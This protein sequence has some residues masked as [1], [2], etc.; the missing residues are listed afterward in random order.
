MKSLIFLTFLSP[1]FFFCFCNCQQKTSFSCLFQTSM[2]RKGQ[3]SIGEFKPPKKRGFGDFFQR[4][5][6]WKISSKFFFHEKPIFVQERKVNRIGLEFSSEWKLSKISEAFSGKLSSFHELLHSSKTQFF[7]RNFTILD[8]VFLEFVQPL[9]MSPNWRFFQH[10][11]VRTV[12]G[13]L[14]WA[15][16]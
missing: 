10:I 15:L 7:R 11:Q 8:R 12:H 13:W 3:K 1:Q 9:S 2:T 5:K 6:I 16:D 4:I 14:I